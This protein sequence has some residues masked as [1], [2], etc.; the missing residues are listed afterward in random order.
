V[1]FSTADI[2]AGFEILLMLGG[3]VLLWRVVLSPA[4]RR[5]RP[6]P[7]LETWPVPFPE[8]FIFLCLIMFGAITAA[9]ISA[10][11]SRGLGLVGDEATVFSG[12]AFQL[13]MLGGI[14]LYHYGYKRTPTPPILGKSNVVV[15]G[16]VT[17][18]ITLP[19]MTVSAAL[20]EWL[21]RS[22]GLPAERQELI[23]MFSNVDSPV[24]LLVLVLL[25]V[26]TA[27]LSE[28]L[29]F[30]A[31][32]F[33]YLRGRVPYSVALLA[34]AIVFGSLHVNWQTLEGLAS[35]GPLVALAVVFSLAYQ[36][37]G[38]IGTSMIAHAL[39][40]LNTILLIFCGVDM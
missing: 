7:K 40:N 29:V 21:L 32:L 30:R 31:G 18:L 10:S 36:R 12:A 28:E 27:P 26:G 13:G 24:M 23:E 6:P 14:A 20:W 34:P 35:L 2:A 17:F 8:F 22:C 33:R 37:T 3:A 19:L 39:F 16:F 25:A 9:F 4:A 11:V 38:R 5:H 15:S 1:P